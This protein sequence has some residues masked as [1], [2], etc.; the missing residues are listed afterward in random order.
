MSDRGQG[1]PEDKLKEVFEQT[2]FHQQWKA[3]AWGRPS[4]AP[5][6]RRTTAERLIWAKKPGFH[7][8]AS[9]RHK[10]SSVNSCDRGA[11]RSGPTSG[12]GLSEMARCPDL[13]VNRLK[14]DIPP[15]GRDSFLTNRDPQGRSHG[16]HQPE[17][18]QCNPFWIIAS[19]EPSAL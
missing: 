19:G 12:I 14:A 15:Q 1:M 11:I 2:S 8:R 16:R 4:R 13:V 18:G 5:L 7:A 6:S 10:A 9:F 17:D 3:G